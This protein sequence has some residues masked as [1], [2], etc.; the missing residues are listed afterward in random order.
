MEA[1]KKL[2]SLYPE[3][4][5]IENGIANKRTPLSVSGTTGS[6]K[7]QLIY[8]VSQNLSKKAFVITSDDINAKQIKNDLEA[9]S[10]KKAYI[11]K[12]K[13]YVFYDVDVSTKE[14]ESDRINV[15]KNINKA[16]FVVASATAVMQ[17]TLPEKIFSEYTRKIKS[18]DIINLE[19]LL[20]NLVNMGYTRVTTVEGE[21]QFSQRGS[22]LDIFLP[23]DTLGTRIE[24]FDNEVD[25]IRR[26][27]TIT[28]I[29]QD[30]INS[31]TLYPARELIFDEQTKLDVIK[32][33]KAQK[34]ENLASDITKLTENGYFS[35][36]D[37]YIP[38]F[39]S[40]LPTIF[41]Y[42]TD[43][44]LIFIDEASQTN[45]RCGIYEK[46]QNEIIVSMLEKG[47]FPKMKGDYILS[48]ALLF[49]KALKHDTVF[50]NGVSH[51]TNFN[52]KE[53]VNLTA[54]TLPSYSGKSEFLIDDISFW[55]KNKYRIMLILSNDDKIKAVKESLYQNGIEAAI[56]KKLDNLPEEGEVILTKGFIEKSFEYPTI[57]TVV[58]SDNGVFAVQ[59]RKTRKISKNKKNIIKSFDELNN[60]DYVV[61]N[62]HGIGQYVGIKE[63]VVEGIVKDY[64][65]IKYRSGDFLYVPTNQLDLLH[66][67]V[68]ADARNVKLN[69][70]GGTEWQKTTSKVKESVMELADD[71]IKLYAQ[72]SEIKGHKFS[73]DTVW[74]KE[75]E[76]EFPYE[77]TAD[78]I[79]CIKE[80]KKDME[81][82][83]CMD[84]LLCGDV[85]YGK[86]EVALRAAFKSVAESFQVAYLVPT[87]LLAQQ[88]YNTFKSRME[89]YP[90]KVEMLSRFR[91]KKQQAEIIKKLKSG[92]IDIVIGTHRLIQKDINFKNLGMLIIDEEQRFGVGHKEAIKK[93]K[94]NVNVLTLSAT[95]IP[96]TLNM[97]LIGIRDLSV[98]SE[99]PQNRYPVQTFVLERNEAVIES[100]VSRE[101]ARGG[102]VYYLYNRVENI[103]VKANEIRKMFPDKKVSTAHGKMSE[104]QLEEIMLDFLNGDIDILICTT[105]IETGLDVA[106]VNTI[107][108]ED[109]DKLGL[110]QLY[111]LRGRVGRSNRL[112]YAYLTYEKSKVLDST[113]QKRLQ[114]I[115]EFTEFGSG[116]KIAMRDLEIRGA[117]NLLGKQQHGNMNLVGYDM[118]CMLLESAVAELKGEKA[119]IAFE[120]NIDLKVSAYIPKEYI[121]DENLRIDMYKRIACI[122]DEE[123]ASNMTD[124]LIDRFGTFDENV[125][126][127]IDIAY[128][129]SLCQSLNIT[130]VVQ[131]D[132][133][134]L[135]TI[136]QNINP[137]VIVDI[138]AEKN[139]KLMFS[140]GEK[141]YLG[142]KYDEN[143]LANIK[144]ILQKLL[145]LS[146]ECKDD[147]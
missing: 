114:A 99:P 60:G 89:A 31:F 120:T 117:G 122:Q 116:F 4:C 107:I 32:K 26:F 30:L 11:F 23:G 95:P 83:K 7:N 108:I 46:E 112:A 93:L 77:E 71:L 2:N 90:I 63:L 135:F 78:Q 38:Y 139:Y 27:D 61:H 137:K 91:T 1:L 47:L 119:Q 20:L 53:I 51:P 28:Q 24:F 141:S 144:I 22:I 86:T 103:E 132:G 113:Q 129:K 143:M 52:L 106:N 13:E 59:K 123:D 42:L 131:K 40:D 36:L 66:K 18:G 96:R 8:S 142:Y 64:I 72:R 3:L 50:I 92:E 88:H 94:N 145:K 126:N 33:I 121:N 44:H 82:G 124:E 87:T 80:V 48:A 43:E 102:Q 45:D 37:K 62:T 134:I 41:D 69:K 12:A 111:Q 100:A 54:K 76:D 68:G 65:K 34:N 49:E 128:I 140:S 6:Q 130:D 74:Q 70:L 39:Y 104:V 25:T 85:G 14:I 97:A 58:L 16:D 73:P 127:L 105:I 81:D 109:A 125:A 147:V 110:S 10:G 84:R 101:M 21:C 136:D 118:Y 138:L 56:S 9:I 29:S 15:I 5:A 79:R 57:K 146:L 19:K 55:K 17:Y 133:Q 98:L 67:Y 115:K 75:F 35:S